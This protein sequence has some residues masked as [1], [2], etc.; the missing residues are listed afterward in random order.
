MD[1]CDLLEA[2]VRRFAALI[3]DRPLEAPVPSCPGWS[4]ADL[5]THLGTVHRWA[6][7]L[8][9]TLAPE[10]VPSEAMGLGPPEPSGVWIRAGGDALVATLR[11]ADPGAAMWSW[12]KDQHVR[13]WSRRQLHETL[14]HRMDAEL[15]LGLAPTT[16]PAIAADAIDEFLVNLASARYFSPKVKNLRGDGTRLVFRANDAGRAWTIALHPEG[17]VVEDGTVEDGTVEDGTAEDGTAAAPAATL[18]GPALPLLLVLY[19]RLPLS[20]PGIE[21]AGDSGVVALWMANSALE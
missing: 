17:Y 19:R 6:E 13:F 21:Q 4:V 20:T 1:D 11:A 15:A 14:V 16:T 18:E 3:D 5:T 12:G 8:V 7:H 9:R 10:R 2:E